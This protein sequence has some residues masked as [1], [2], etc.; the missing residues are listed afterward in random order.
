M[1][2]MNVLKTQQ[3]S[4]GSTALDTRE[5]PKEDEDDCCLKMKKFV[6]YRMNSLDYAF[7]G[8]F[9]TQEH[10]YSNWDFI[11][12][13]DCEI[14]LNNAKIQYDDMRVFD[15]YSREM[16]LIWRESLEVYKRCMGEQTT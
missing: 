8:G 14:F 12:D 4:I 3:V 16:K 10:K 6:I 5:I 13:M 7:F 11:L 2:W 15:N 1:D 9:G